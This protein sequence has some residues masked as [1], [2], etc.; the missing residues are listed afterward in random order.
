MY[1][2]ILLYRGVYSGCGVEENDAVTEDRI[3]ISPHTLSLTS[4]VECHPSHTTHHSL[5][6][7]TAIPVAKTR[8][9]L[10]YS[11]PCLPQ[12]VPYN[13]PRHDVDS[14]VVADGN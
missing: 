2:I 4:L 8:S 13:H 14:T 1:L 9:T 3:N 7:D 12:P 10:S 11:I 5:V 6:I